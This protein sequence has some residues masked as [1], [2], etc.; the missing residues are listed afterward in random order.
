MKDEPELAKERQVTDAKSAEGR[1]D[2]AGVATLVGRTFIVCGG[3]FLVRALTASGRVTPLMGA[4]RAGSAEIVQMLLERGAD[5][6]AADS[7]G[8]RAIDYTSRERSPAVHALLDTA[9][10][11]GRAA[12]R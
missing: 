9:M 3:A 10:K 11:R 6:H 5:P 8:H 7:V 4:A 2:L 12:S 1:A